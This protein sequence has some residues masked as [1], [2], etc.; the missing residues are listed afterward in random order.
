MATP[1]TIERAVRIARRGRERR[2]AN[3]SLSMG[4]YSSDLI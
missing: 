1:R 4:G 3:V 2:L